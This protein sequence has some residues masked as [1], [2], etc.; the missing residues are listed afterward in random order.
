MNEHELRRVLI[1]ND[2]A[3]LPYPLPADGERVHVIRGNGPREGD[4]M[5]VATVRLD[6]DGTVHLIPDDERD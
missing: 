2:E 3:H 5:A 4:L 6:D 1:Y